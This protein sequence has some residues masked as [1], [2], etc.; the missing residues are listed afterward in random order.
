M[1]NDFKPTANVLSGNTRPGRSIPNSFPRGNDRFRIE[2]YGITKKDL[3]LA[4]EIAEKN[5]TSISKVLA[6][7][8]R[9]KNVPLQR[10]T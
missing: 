5:K 10:R 2:R 6:E 7:I 9:Q 3:E 8:I 4:R 1:L